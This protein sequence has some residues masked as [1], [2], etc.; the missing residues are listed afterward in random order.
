[1]KSASFDPKIDLRGMTMMDA[2]KVLEEFMDNAVL[3]SSNTIRIVHGKGD[4]VLRKVVKKKLKEYK[5]IKR[6][7]HPENNEGGMGLLLRRCDLSCWF[8]ILNTFYIK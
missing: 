6:Q 7:F 8:L 5:E 2:E 1:M 3:S 4:G